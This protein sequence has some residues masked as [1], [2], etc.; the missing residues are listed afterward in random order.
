M[1]HATGTPRPAPRIG[2]ALL[3]VLAIGAC[4]APAPHVSSVAARGVQVY[5]WD[6]DA[7]GR[8]AW[9]FVGPRAVLY[10]ETERE[11]GTHAKG[12]AGPE[13]SIGTDRTVGEKRWERPSPHPD[14]IPELLLSARPAGDG[15][16]FGGVRWI[17]RLE[18][19]GGV[20]PPAEGPHRAGDEVDVPYRA[21]YRFL[22]ECP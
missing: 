18:T 16:V 17:E 2:A 22:T 21:K 19:E 20:A 13:W 12:D 5:R 4:R 9:K 8:A 14:S 3:A 15:S 7:N 11:I 6:V 1:S 10:D